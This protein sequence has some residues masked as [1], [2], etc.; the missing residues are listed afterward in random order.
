MK[1]DTQAL[2]AKLAYCNRLRCEVAESIGMSRGTF[3]A[4]LKNG[5]FKISEIHKLMKIIPLSM[6]DV[7]SI[8]F[9][10]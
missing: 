3:R 2:K 7:H 4:K 1:V 10:D 9:A 5:D 6:N 8:F